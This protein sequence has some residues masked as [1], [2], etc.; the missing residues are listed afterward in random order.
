MYSG[1]TPNHSGT[2][3]DGD[4]ATSAALRVADSISAD[5]LQQLTGMTRP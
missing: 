1:T 2:T 3:P 5:R 4:I